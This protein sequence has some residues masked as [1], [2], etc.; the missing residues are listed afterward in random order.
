LARAEGEV[1]D[2]EKYVKEMVGGRRATDDELDKIA[3]ILLAHVRE[4]VRADKEVESD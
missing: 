3:G 1:I 4:Q 2:V